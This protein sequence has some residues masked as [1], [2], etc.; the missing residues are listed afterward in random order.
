MDVCLCVCGRISHTDSGGQKQ[1]THK[2]QQNGEETM[3]IVLTK[4]WQ[5]IV[6]AWH[7]S[8]IVFLNKKTNKTPHYFPILIMYKTSMVSAATINVSHG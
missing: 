8:K 4:M 2:L 3:S 6:L 1:R 7:R 5:A